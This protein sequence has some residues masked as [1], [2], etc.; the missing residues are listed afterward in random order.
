MEHLPYHDIQGLVVRG[1]KE[2]PFARFLLL[3]FEK[4]GDVRA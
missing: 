2:L 4:A 1:Y 3:R